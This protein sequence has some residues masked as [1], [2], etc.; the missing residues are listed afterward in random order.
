MS[1]NV[2]AAAA[3]HNAEGVDIAFGIAEG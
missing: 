2:A 3:G 1:R